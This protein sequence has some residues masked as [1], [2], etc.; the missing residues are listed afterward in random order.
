MT[1]FKPVS[2]IFLFAAGDIPYEL[3]AT[4]AADFAGPNWWMIKKKNAFRHTLFG[5]V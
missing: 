3:K 5:L 4:H 1:T 2:P